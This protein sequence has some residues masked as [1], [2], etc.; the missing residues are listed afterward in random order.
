VST[1]SGAE[2]KVFQALIGNAIRFRSPEAPVVEISAAL[3]FVNPDLCRRFRPPEWVAIQERR[4]SI[5]LKLDNFSWLPP[6]DSH[7]LKTMELSASRFKDI[8][9]CIR[10][11]F[12]YLGYFE[13]P[14]AA[15]FEPLR[16]LL[17]LEC[18]IS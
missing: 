12:P 7:R 1:G 2:L 3:V 8:P 17:D 15:F 4:D 16:I 13:N 11:R 18:A 9:S 14:R 5:P 6:R 10:R